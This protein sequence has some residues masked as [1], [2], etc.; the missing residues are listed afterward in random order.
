M[1]LSLSALLLV[2]SLWTAATP[3]P[4][5]IVVVGAAG[6]AEFGDQ[7]QTWAKRW[8]TAADQGGAECQMIGLSA[9]PAGT[10]DRQTL[11]DSLG[12]LATSNAESA[13]KSPLWL[14]LI[15]H[16]TFD[17]KT[18]RFNLQGPDLSAADLA[19]AMQPLSGP[20]A[21]INCASASGPFVNS[22]SAPG[23]VV[24]TATRSGSESNFARF[25]D[26]FSAA[27]LDQAADLDKDEQVSLLE[28]F[29]AA[30]AK[31]REFYADAGRLATEHPLL[32]DNGDRLG[33]PA[34]WFEG[35]VAVKS[36]KSGA[37]PDGPIASQWTLIRSAVE[38]E[39]PTEIRARRD[40]LEQELAR[41]RHQKG[42]LAEDDYLD[43]IEPVLLEL[44]R[45]GQGHEPQPPA[46]R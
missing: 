46:T 10:S 31:V 25:G 33:T 24:I 2:G 44:S 3:P 18:A 45:L 1:T 26:G 8:K 16:G 35:V 27:L 17:G 14:V 28:A 42:Q 9:Q 43:L 32:D 7:F 4:R 20:V 38:Q 37:R 34:D 21:V 41:L 12:R 30:A 22:L 39:L 13:G 23:R 19:A 11:L 40:Q 36:A 15:G 29:L 5:V 6:S